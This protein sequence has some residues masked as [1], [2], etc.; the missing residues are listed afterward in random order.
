MDYYESKET[1]ASK[2]VDLEIKPVLDYI[3]RAVYST[4]QDPKQ[5]FGETLDGG[6]GARVAEHLLALAIVK[7]A[8]QSS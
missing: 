5:M 7:Q 1:V 2:W 3:A 8:Q 6:S 4:V